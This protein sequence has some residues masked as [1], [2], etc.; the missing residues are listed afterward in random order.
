MASQSIVLGDAKL[1]LSFPEFTMKVDTT[2]GSVDA[3]VTKV[4][5]KTIKVS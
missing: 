2:F 3:T 4:D 1:K 5:I